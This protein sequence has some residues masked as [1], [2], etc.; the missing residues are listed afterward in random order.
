[1][2]EL[3]APGAGGAWCLEPP[4]SPDGRDEPTRPVPGWRCEPSE[5]SSERTVRLG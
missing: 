4:L 1:M 3:E 2:E 5:S